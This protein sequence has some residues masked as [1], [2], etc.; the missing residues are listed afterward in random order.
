VQGLLRKEKLSFQVETECSHCH[1]PL[2]IEM[3]SDLNYQVIEKGAKPLIFSPMVDFSRLK[4]P[5][6]IDAF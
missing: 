1:A 3:D 5:S 6:I 2:H 4:D